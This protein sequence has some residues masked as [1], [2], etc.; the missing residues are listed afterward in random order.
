MTAPTAL[1]LVCTA[2]LSST[3]AGA[4]T[5]PLI[6]RVA[7]ALTAAPFGARAVTV[8]VLASGVPLIAKPSI[9]AWVTVYAPEQVAVL[10]VFAALSGAMVAIVQLS[11]GIFGSVTT[12]LLRVAL[13]VLVIVNP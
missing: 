11:A 10:T 5:G 2:V 9:S 4:A 1:K 12:T 8:A 13:P 6:A 3:M 7:V